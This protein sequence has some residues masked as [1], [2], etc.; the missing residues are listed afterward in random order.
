VKTILKEERSEAC[1]VAAMSEPLLAADFPPGAVY[2][3]AILE[4]RRCAERRCLSAVPPA[5]RYMA[6]VHD[7]VETFAN[8]S[9]RVV[10]SATW[11]SA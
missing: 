3:L 9:L 1:K 6:A 8:G 11:R 4:A 10:V 5:V 2:A 7:T